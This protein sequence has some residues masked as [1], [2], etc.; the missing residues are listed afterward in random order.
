MVNVPIIAASWFESDVENGDGVP[1]MRQFIEVGF[2]GEMLSV[3][4]IEV[5]ESEKPPYDPG[6]ICSLPMVSLSTTRSPA[7]ILAS[8]AILLSSNANEGET[9]NRRSS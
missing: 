9:Q 2:S 6:P 5:A 3:G 1:I 8:A 7:T 4:F